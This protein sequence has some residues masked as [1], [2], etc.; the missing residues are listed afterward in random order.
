VSVRESSV[1]SQP[2]IFPQSLESALFNALSA[3]RTRRSRA[4]WRV[5]R[6]SFIR[7]TASLSGV[8]LKLPMVWWMS[9]NML[10]EPRDYALGSYSRGIL[11]EKHVGGV[12]VL[13]RFWD[14]RA[15]KQY[16]VTK[17]VLFFID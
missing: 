2:L 14:L 17:C 4:C 8:M 12:Y 10:V 6:D 9:W 3:S 1:Y 16:E 15:M 7:E 11:V 5:D 13:M